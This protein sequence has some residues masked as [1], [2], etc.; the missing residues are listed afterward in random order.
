MVLG[1]EWGSV[2]SSIFCL[3]R[4]VIGNGVLCGLKTN[5][6]LFLLPNARAE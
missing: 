4:S 6:E 5:P 1:T 3:M 2:P